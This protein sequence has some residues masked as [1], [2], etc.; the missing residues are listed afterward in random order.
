MLNLISKLIVFLIMVNFGVG[1]PVD[2]NDPSYFPPYQCENQ[3]KQKVVL[4][5][6]KNT[7]NIC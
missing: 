5:N 7:E 1:F 2:P 6:K 4:L 3:P